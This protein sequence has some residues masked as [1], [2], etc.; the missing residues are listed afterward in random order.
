M[1]RPEEKYPVPN[2]LPDVRFVTCFFTW[3]SY[4]NGRYSTGYRFSPAFKRA[5]TNKQ[6]LIAAGSAALAVDLS[7]QWIIGKLRN[8]KTL[9]HW[10]TNY[11][12][13]AHAA[14][15]NNHD[16]DRNDANTE[17]YCGRLKK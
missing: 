9:N 1:P 12:C 3:Q 4:S 11:Y 15:Q 7:R 16:R 2:Y 6:S 17:E 13:L 8:E 5:V 14:L 10:F